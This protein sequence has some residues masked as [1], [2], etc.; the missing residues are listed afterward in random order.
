MTRTVRHALVGGAMVAM[1]FATAGAAQTQSS[2]TQQTAPGQS[3]NPPARGTRPPG[4]R[5]AGARAG[6]LPA[7]SPNMTPQQL[8]SYID[9]FAVVEAERQL[10]LS[11]EQYGAFVPRLRR[12]Q[13]LRRRHAM[14]RR[15]MLDELNGLLNSESP[16]E[17]AITEKVRTI[18]E[19]APRAAAELRK[20]Y[21]EID[22]LLTPAQQA[23]LRLMDE[24]IERRKIEL[25]GKITA[26]PPA[27]RG[28]R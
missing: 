17:E 21:E 23:R 3:V 20:A 15:R 2:G 6:A 9:A 19:A 28:G 16:R 5:A 11:A 25:L 18:D 13:D 7:L 22:A 8:Q 26:T 1:S 12:I 4:G 24:R 27:G 10:Q 14:E